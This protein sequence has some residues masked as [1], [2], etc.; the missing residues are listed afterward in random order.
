MK[1]IKIN[2]TKSKLNR[3]GARKYATVPSDTSDEVEYIVTKIRKRNKKDY[4]YNCT[5]PDFVFRQNPC[6][7]I[8]KFILE[9]NKTNE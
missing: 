8:K 7:H 1:T 2:T 5:C 4:K 9:E 6:K 3:F